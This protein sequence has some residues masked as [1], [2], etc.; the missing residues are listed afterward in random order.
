M[1]AETPVPL[2]RVLFIADIYGRVGWET[3]VR[4]WPDLMARRVHLVVANG[5]NAADGRGITPEWAQTYHHQG[6]DVITGGNHIWDKPQIRKAFREFPYLLRPLNYPPGS[7]GQGTAVVTAR[8]GTKVAV[9]NLQGRTYM[10]PIDC[11]FRTAAREIARLKRLTPVIIIDF[12]AEATAEKQALAWH[13]DGKV[14]AVIGTHT[15]VQT[16]DERVLPGGTAFITDAGMTGPHDSVIGNSISG[17]VSRFI[18][19]TPHTYEVA[20]GNPRFN[21]VLL[22]IDP[23]TG[24]ASRIERLALP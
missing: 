4:F 7:G 21:G 3:V 20:Q 22:D 2:L 6:I 16:A 15:H 13:L 19:Q 17:A 9:I 23:V 11:P 1:P 24:K 18:H 5:E 8:D 10:T 14:S 12:H